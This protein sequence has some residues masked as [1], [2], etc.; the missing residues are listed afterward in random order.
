MATLGPN[1]VT[2]ITTSV[3]TTDIAF[4]EYVDNHTGGITATTD[5]DNGKLLVSDGSTSSW[6]YLSTRVEFETPGTTN[7]TVPSRVNK[8]LISAS[9]G[10][11]GGGVGEI[12]G[13]TVPKLS[14]WTQ[15]TGSFGSYSN[16]YYGS[17]TYGDSPSGNKWVNTGQSA[18]VE[19]S[20][21][22]IHWTTKTHGNS[23]NSSYWWDGTYANGEFL[24][25][26]YNYSLIA[27]TDSIHW[28]ARTANF[29]VQYNTINYGA[30]GNYCIAGDSGRIL[31]STDAVHWIA[32][33]GTTA[34]DN[35]WVGYLNNDWHM[36]GQSNTYS[37]STDTI[38]W[39]ARTIGNTMQNVTM[40]YHAGQQTYLMFKQ[41]AYHSNEGTSSGHGIWA[42]TDSITWVA[43]TSD[44]GGRTINYQ[45]FASEYIP[46]TQTVVACGSYVSVVASTDTIHWTYSKSRP[47]E[48]GSEENFDIATDD[49]E[50]VLITGRY[51]VMIRNSPLK[52]YGIS[53]GGGGGAAA[54]RYEIN[55]NDISKNSTL[56]VTVGAGGRGGGKVHSEQ[57]TLRTMGIS[58]NRLEQNGYPAVKYGGYWV[59]GSKISA[60]TDSIHWSARTLPPLPASTQAWGVAYGDL[61]LMTSGNNYFLCT[62]T[63]SIVWTLRT[64]SIDDNRQMFY[65]GIGTWLVAGGPSGGTPNGLVVSTDTIHWTRRTLGANPATQ[66]GF[67]F[68]GYDTY[69]LGTYNSGVAKS[70]GL[71]S[72]TDTIHWTLRTLGFG[73][74]NTKKVNYSYA[75]NNFYIVGESNSLLASTDAIHWA[76]RTV[77]F[78]SGNVIYSYSTG[79]NQHVIGS[80]DG[81][82]TSTDSIHWT[83]RTHNFT[84]AGPRYIGYGD[85]KFMVTNGSGSPNYKDEIAILDVSAQDGE[86][87]TISWKGKGVADLTIG[88]DVSVSTSV[89]PTGASSSYS[90]DGT[91]DYLEVSNASDMGGFAGD[92]SIE[93][94]FKGGNQT[95]FAVFLE[96]YGPSGQRWAI[97]AENAGTT[98][99]IWV[100]DGGIK[101][102]TSGI[103]ALDDAWHHHAVVRDGSTIT[104]YIDGVSRGSETFS[105]TLSSGTTL[106][107]G[108][109]SSG[110]YHINGNL[111][112]VRIV[113]GKAIYTE[114][115]T[116][117]TPDLQFTDHTV[118]LT[119]NGSDVSGIDAQQTYSITVPGGNG[120]NKNTGG[121]RLEES[122][123]QNGY[124]YLPSAADSSTGTGN[125][126][127]GLGGDG[128]SGNSLYVTSYAYQS[129]GG[130]GAGGAASYP[131]SG[132]GAG[133]QRIYFNSLPSGNPPT[134]TTVDG[135]DGSRYRDSVYGL[136]AYG[137]SATSTKTLGSF[138]RR[139]FYG[140]S[141]YSNQKITGTY[142]DYLGLFVLANNTTNNT[143]STTHLQVSTDTIHWTLRTYPF[144]SD[145]N[146]NWTGFYN[147]QRPIDDDGT[148]V[149]LSN[150]NRDSTAGTNPNTLAVSTDTIHWILRT[151]ATMVS[152]TNSPNNIKYGNNMWLWAFNGDGLQA[153]TDTIHWTLRTQG[154]ASS[155]SMNSLT[156]GNGRWVATH[157]G[158]GNPYTSTDT[159]HWI[160]RTAGM[161]NSY[162]GYGIIYAEPEDGENIFVYGSYQNIAWSTDGIRW[163]KRTQNQSHY[164]LS[165]AY[166]SVLNKYLMTDYYGRLF[167]FDASGPLEDLFPANI[168]YEPGSTYQSGYHIFAT[169]DANVIYTGDSYY[170]VQS[171]IMTIDLGNGG[172]G[173]PGAGGG[174]AGVIAKSA[175]SGHGGDGGDGS[176]HISMI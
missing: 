109:Y 12:D 76:K 116:P 26:G 43:R 78:G 108:K 144:P 64:T 51:N 161:N 135:S 57:W 94:W 79:Y 88:G 72:S 30:D 153:S 35:E 32:R 46:S 134:P 150:T 119:C 23:S 39:T 99:M 16:Y 115:F 118:L 103:D 65:D 128:S 174:G 83:L 56:D 61:L 52:N 84:A 7:Y 125:I 62:S 4:K 54:P 40:S 5:S 27:S 124:T 117:P 173:G 60:S 105:G 154:F 9:G 149:L 172:K 104:Y 164:I 80:E 66:T 152:G 110:S 21:D 3:N 69:V 147:V 166:S 93:F 44:F 20:T 122:D 87:T 82:A 91:G 28:F 50:R 127:F 29:G 112:N 120:A 137:G 141:G 129:P 101:F 160:A 131:S 139:T 96:H 58:T 42:S 158:G 31:A 71:S 14:S 168:A 145:T 157:T 37:V 130:G 45:F 48:N 47:E 49:S 24:L 19:S 156:Y 92:F 148:Q 114:A 22:S 165:F 81:I 95:G 132:T 55:G 11:G 6:E 53:G 1:Y 162:Q 70:N 85:Q 74:L 98:N 67:A 13:T 33:T 59:V 138:V 73:S 102:T 86:D 36:C 10:G 15:R 63:D 170:F 167:Q 2:G 38:H 77:P 146:F 140:M 34:S 133:Y 126:A 151:G 159:I 123:I 107:I 90:F 171:N 75:T 106:G 175:L 89:K 25:V 163:F 169:D 143:L 8:L 17:I 100:R 136:G 113:K 142:I 176:V 155:A 121:S 41:N 111:S 97:Q 18:R 68:N